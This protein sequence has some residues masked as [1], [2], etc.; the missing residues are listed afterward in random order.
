MKTRCLSD[1]IEQFE[2]R[3][4]HLVKEHPGKYVLIQGKEELGIF[5]TKEAALR[6]GYKRFQKRAFLVKRI[7]AT[8]R[9]LSFL[10]NVRVPE[11]CQL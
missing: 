11:D 8:E 3:L 6:E 7:Q 10:S 5:D 1:E 4:P 2:A 9:A